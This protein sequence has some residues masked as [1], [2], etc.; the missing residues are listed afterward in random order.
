MEGPILQQ[1]AMNSE[2]MITMGATDDNLWEC[3]ALG[4]FGWEY[5][6]DP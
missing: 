6:I 1:V 5:R 2:G 3:S 4:L